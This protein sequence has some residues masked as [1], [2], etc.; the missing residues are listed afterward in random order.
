MSKEETRVGLGWDNGGVE[1]CFHLD[2][3]YGLGQKELKLMWI[4]ED[5]KKKKAGEQQG[6]SV[7]STWDEKLTEKYLFCP[8]SAGE[9]NQTDATQEWKLSL[10][11]DVTENAYEN[12]FSKTR[13]PFQFVFLTCGLMYMKGTESA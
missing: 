6:A 7:L 11:N 10:M 12:M 5:E 2:T 1:Y 4:K 13:T 8:T 3:H 9:R